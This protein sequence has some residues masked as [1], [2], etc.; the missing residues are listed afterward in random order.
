MNSDVSSE[1]YEESIGEDSEDDESNESEDDENASVPR[2]VA[3]RKLK[4]NMKSL[5]V[6]E[7]L[8]LIKESVYNHQ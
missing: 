8:N 5:Q 7:S 2:N 1:E 3:R 6:H 4:V